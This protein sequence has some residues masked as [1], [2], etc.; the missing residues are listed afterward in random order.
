MT[1]V[2][3]ETRDFDRLRVCAII[4]LEMRVKQMER[5]ADKTRPL[6]EESFVMEQCLTPLSKICLL[7]HAPTKLSF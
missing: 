4:R 6:D 1:L 3:W 5:G 7:G 2:I